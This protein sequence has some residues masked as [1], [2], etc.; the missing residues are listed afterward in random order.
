MYAIGGSGVFMKPMSPDRRRVT[1]VV[2]ALSR[3]EPDA[4]IPTVRKQKLPSFLS[5]PVG[6][7]LVTNALLTVPQ[8]DKL[9][10]WFTCDQ[11]RESEVDGKHLV[12]AARYRKWNM[13]LSASRSM[14]ESGFYGPKWAAWVYAVPKP[15]NSLIRSA[16]IDHGF[17]LIR[18]WYSRPRTELWLTTSHDY[19]LWYSPADER[20]T[21]TATDT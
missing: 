1:L 12:F 11:D 10:L 16:L 19:S 6:A 4:V 8:V 17:E 15:L 2:I 20:L 9:E 13:G 21:A 18:G 5:Y 3:V 14:D 7:Q